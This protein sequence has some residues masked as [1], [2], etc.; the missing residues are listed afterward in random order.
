MT[1]AST[2][3]TIA[4]TGGTGFVGRALIEVLRHRGHPIRALA[5]SSQKPEP[6]VEWVAGDLTDR[7]ALDALLLG[8]GGLIHAA[9]LTRSRDPQAF[10]R[11]NVDGT[12]ALLKAWG[13]QGGESDRPRL[14]LVS[15]LAAREPRLSAYGASKRRAEDAVRAAAPGAAI[16]RPPA[17]YG[18]R[19]RD[20]LQLFRAAKWGV[21]PVPADGAS[22]LIWV[23][24]LAELLA[25]LVV[26]RAACARARYSNPMTDGPMAGRTAN[27]RRPS[28]K[29]SG[30]TPACSRSR[31]GNA[32]KGGASRIR[33][34]AATRRGSRPT[35]RPTWRIRTG[36]PLP[37]VG[38][39]ETLWAPRMETSEGL[40][41]TANWYRRHGW[42]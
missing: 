37:G 8:S 6:G 5:R 13:R 26:D 11:A 2:P 18:P 1:S 17:V 35:A 15:S 33:N 20:M 19:D 21:V 22:S 24:D 27:W 32:A 3:A 36:C 29:R 14:V 12:H 9:G 39:P 41:R 7:G 38:V 16:V 23:Y 4:L 40:R 10:E 30:V 42:L 28:A 31:P 25:T 34:C